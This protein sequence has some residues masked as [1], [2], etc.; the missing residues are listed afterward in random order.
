LQVATDGVEEFDLLSSIKQLIR[1]YNKKPTKEELVVL[2]QKILKLLRGYEQNFDY[3]L[4]VEVDVE[5]EQATKLHKIDQYIKFLEVTNIKEYLN[6]LKILKQ[7]AIY[8]VYQDFRDLKKL[9]RYVN[10]LQKLT[11]KAVQISKE[12]KTEDFPDVKL[13][14][15]NIG[16]IIGTIYFKNLNAI[17]A[18][19]IIAMGF[20]GTRE[21]L[22]LFCKRIANQNYLVY[23]FNLPAHGES[24]AIFRLSLVSEYIFISVK[25]IRSKFNLRRIAVIGHSIGS[26][27]AMMAA[28]GYNR[29]AEYEIYKFAEQYSNHLKKLIEFEKK[30]KIIGLYDEIIKN[31]NKPLLWQKIK[32]L[33]S[34]QEKLL[35]LNNII[36]D[37]SASYLNIKLIILSS[38]KEQWYGGGKIDA[39]IFLAPPLKLQKIVPNPPFLIRRIPRNF[40]KKLAN[41]FFNEPI[42][43]FFSDSLDRFTEANRKILERKGIGD[44]ITLQFFKIY[45][46]K[47]FIDYFFSIK[48]PVDY[49]GLIN[50]LSEIELEK[51]EEIEK[52]ELLRRREKIKRIYKRDTSKIDSELKRLEDTKPILSFIR[53][54]KKRLIDE[55]PKLFLYGTFDLW[56]K[57]FLPKGKKKFESVFAMMGNSQVISL[58]RQS[59]FLDKEGFQTSTKKPLS[60]PKACTYIIDFL[61]KNL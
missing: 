42:Y 27:A 44:L 24:E 59:H 12:A 20:F 50:F 33:I 48:N 15:Y 25:N 22:N 26:V 28:C 61:N 41:K 45:D 37:L 4:D 47:D 40:V 13:R 52:Q 10:N 23:I 60:N 32:N 36:N 17:K 49:L 29:T 3:L 31:I 58:K 19:V 43:K 35:I 38:L 7:R 11:S 39:F 16:E 6:E 5:I 46:L 14:P 53:A 56:L 51:V 1:I 21:E 18:G 9:I 34:E 55:K 8:W 2:E 57:P 30:Y 54:Y